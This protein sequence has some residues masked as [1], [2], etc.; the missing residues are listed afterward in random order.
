MPCLLIF[1]DSIAIEDI[2]KTALKQEDSIILFP[3][4]SKQRIV[5]QV[6][7]KCYA[8]GI[9]RA[10]TLDTGQ[11]INET[12]DEVRD[13]YIEFI[14]RLPDKFSINGKNLKEWFYYPDAG[15]SLW[16]LSLV[17][18]KNTFKSN[19]F[20]KLVQLYSI[21]RII[22]E[23]QPKKVALS[24]SSKKLSL[25]LT[26]YCKENSTSL[27]LLHNRKAHRINRLP[28]KYPTI[29]ALTGAIGYLG[30]EMV[31]WTCIKLF[32]KNSLRKASDAGTDNPLLVITYYP[33]I[34]VESA[35]KGIFKNRYYPSLQEELERQGRDITWAALYI[36]NAGISHLESLQYARSFIRS[37]YH[38]V[39]LEQFLTAMSFARMLKGLLWSLKKFRR[40]EKSLPTHHY[41]SETIPIYPIF[42]DE[43][44][45]SFCGATAIQG[46][47]YPEAFKNMFHKVSEVQKGLYYC[48]MHA[49][50]KALLATKKRYARNLNLFGYQHATVSRMLLNYFNHH[51]ELE[52]ADSKYAMPKPDK[53][54]CDGQVPYNYFKESGWHEDELTIVE[55]IR[56]DHLKAAIQH[57]SKNRD[58]I[59]LVAFS[60]GIEEST[61][62]LNMV[63]EALKD[64][65]NIKVWLKPHPFLGMDLILKE[66]GIS[67]DNVHFEIKK[68]PVERLLPEAKGVI[69]GGSGTS[70]EALAYGCKVITLNLPE[71]VNMSPLRGIQSNLVNYV[72]SVSQLQEAVSKLMKQDEDNRNQEEAR[73]LVNRFLYLSKTSAKPERFLDLLA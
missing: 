54:A 31:R 3:L 21:V 46:F 37:G 7:D 1:D 5:N 26:L 6:R 42:Q 63:H 59:I 25:A 38:F 22:K 61:A 45:E 11:I 35:S 66:S 14:A 55:A 62:I 48:E 69:I 43:W 65:S 68:D 9:N 41:F 13:K 47:L 8:A 27:I 71:M 10:E 57:K 33:N 15:I 53:I 52:K 49:W 73:E 50:E 36:H 17:A 67:L 72:S 39:F 70:L 64:A 20:H 29:R 51:S 58:N 16:W 40:I 44:Y 28:D 4:T 56:Y 2:D 12:A 34:D 19:S 32:M 60:I 23:Q 18:E 24:C 30:Y